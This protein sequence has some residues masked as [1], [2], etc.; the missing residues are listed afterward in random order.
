MFVCLSC[1][2]GGIYLLRSKESDITVT[3]LAAMARPA[4]SGRKVMP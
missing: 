3:E 1:S 2:A 4:S